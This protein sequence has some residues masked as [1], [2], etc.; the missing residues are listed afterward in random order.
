MNAEVIIEN[1]GRKIERIIQR[2][3]ALLQDYRKVCS[4]RDRLRADNRDLK[5][6]IAALERR[7]S[8]LEIAGGLNGAEDRKAARARINRL[9]REVDKCLELVGKTES[10]TE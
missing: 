9:M 3:R 2:D 4:Q 8:T 10:V 1:L 7:I 5:E 6:R